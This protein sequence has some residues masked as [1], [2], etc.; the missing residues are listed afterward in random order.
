[1]GKRSLSSWKE[2]KMPFGK[3]KGR[4]IDEIRTIDLGYCAWAAE[5]LSSGSMRELF[6][7]ALEHSETVD[8]I[9]SARVIDRY[10]RRNAEPEDSYD[11][12]M[13]RFRR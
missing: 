11:H 3:H 2:F 4:T 1:M 10:H 8:P 6:L 9:S 7:A 13:R 5:E 12:I